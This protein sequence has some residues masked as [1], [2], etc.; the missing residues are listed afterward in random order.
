MKVIAVVSAK[1]GVGKTTLTAN[2]AT[3]LQHQGVAT[4][5]VLDTDAQ[6]ALALH[7][8]GDPQAIAGVSRATLAGQDWASVCVRGASGVFVLPYGLVNETDRVAFE[9]HLDAHP[10]WMAQQLH[11]LHLPADAVVLIDTPPGPSVYMQQALTAAH[12]VVVV[13]RPDAASSAALALM[14][15]DD[16]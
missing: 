7:F 1:G 15:D 2:L 3:A 11:N 8:G 9:R 5:C 14:Q 10:G 13:S 16:E 6:N 4:V 12:A